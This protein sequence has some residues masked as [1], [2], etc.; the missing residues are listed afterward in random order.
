MGWN[1]WC[2][3]ENQIMAYENFGAF[4]TGIKGVL[5]PDFQ[6]NDL[7]TYWEWYRVA[8][9]QQEIILG[10]EQDIRP[11]VQKYGYAQ[12]GGSILAGAKTWDIYVNDCW[13]LGGIHSHAV[14]YLATVMNFNSVYNLDQTKNSDSTRILYVTTREI[15][16]LNLFGYSRTAEKNPKGQKFEC[17]QP[18]VA[19]NASFMEYY[20]HV[21]AVAG[22]VR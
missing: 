2:I 22:A 3:E 4:E 5:K 9:A 11:L 20:Q 15:T 6:K 21:Q 8:R 10:R 1:C 19:T 12:A 14:F 16:G 13:I 18:N 7:K 17:T